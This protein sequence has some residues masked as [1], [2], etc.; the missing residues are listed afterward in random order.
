MRMSERLPIGELARIAGLSPFHFSRQFKI[1]TGLTPNRYLVCL[2]IE[3]AKL[4]LVANPEWSLAQ[5]A[6]FVGY[7]SIG[8]F[9]GLFRRETGW[10]PGAFRQG[11]PAPS[12][13]D[14][15]HAGAF[16]TLP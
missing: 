1:E 2:R 8:Q 9:S 16:P 6:A 15:H 11:A 7:R 10:S 14:W 5:I 13:G 12:L 3:R 4:L